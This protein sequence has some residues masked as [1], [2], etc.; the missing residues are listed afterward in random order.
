MYRRGNCRFIGKNNLLE[1]AKKQTANQQMVYLEI[2]Y[3]IHGRGSFQI[4]RVSLLWQYQDPRKADAS[5][6]MLGPEYLDCLIPMLPFLACSVS[7][8]DSCRASLRT[9]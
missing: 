6:C 8:S 2:L 5:K 1:K 7:R 9:V 3:Y 4:L